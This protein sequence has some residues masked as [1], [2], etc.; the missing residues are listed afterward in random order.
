MSTAATTAPSLADTH[1]H[2]VNAFVVGEYP[3]VVAGVALITGDRSA[4]EDA[5]Q[6]AM[7]AA[8]QRRGEIDNLPAWITVVA[9]NRARNRLRKRS[10]ERKALQRV[11]RGLAE[12][13][14]EIVAERLTM[15]AAVEM[16]PERQRQAVVMHYY[17]DLSVAACAA[18]LGVHE[19]R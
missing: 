16:L 7:V 3:K 18:A 15:A 1:R 19:A 6:D 2:E 4:A 13:G 8:W 14:S 11:E 9:S 10:N 12:A 5:V 17:L